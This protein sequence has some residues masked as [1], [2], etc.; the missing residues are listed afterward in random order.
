M[1]A[2][3][4]LRAGSVLNPLSLESE[5][6]DGLAGDAPLEQLGLAVRCGVVVAHKDLAGPQRAGDGPRREMGGEAQW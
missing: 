6:P 5:E 4:N 2:V 1:F 3:G